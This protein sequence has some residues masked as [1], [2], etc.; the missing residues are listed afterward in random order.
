MKTVTSRIIICIVACMMLGI[1]GLPAMANMHLD[2][3]PG[4]STQVPSISI[5][6]VPGMYVDS[7]PGM[8]TQVPSMSI[9]S[10]P[11]MY[12]D[13]LQVPDYTADV[14]LVIPKIP[15]LPNRNT[16]PKF[17]GKI[18]SA[19]NFIPKITDTS[20]ISKVVLSPGIE[21]ASDFSRRAQQPGDIVQRGVNGIVVFR[22]GDLGV[23]DSYNKQGRLT[24]QW[25][26]E[27]GFHWWTEKDGSISSY[28]DKTGI[29]RNT[30][31]GV[32][33]AKDNRS[34]SVV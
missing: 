12:V 26:R 8:S 27:T 28:D 10:L 7:V 4:I 34:E 11:G 25:D 5:G 20:G 1:I 17:G 24:G 19:N 33:T 18:T 30:K 22:G 13:S 16:P 29:E 32:T 31:N 15:P 3:V 9:D 14:P 21:S 2:S 23:M 6:S